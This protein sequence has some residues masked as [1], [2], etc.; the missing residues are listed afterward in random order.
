LLLASAVIAVYL[1]HLMVYSSKRGL[2]SNPRSKFNMS[3]SI[4]IA[5]PWDICGI[6]SSH[7]LTEHHRVEQNQNTPLLSLPAEIRGR[8]WAYAV[9]GA[10]LRPRPINPYRTSGRHH[11]KL[12]PDDCPHGMAL[13]RVCRQIYSE[14]AF[15][16]LKLS[17]LLFDNISHSWITHAKS[18]ISQLKPHQRRQIKKIRFQML[19]IIDANQVDKQEVSDMISPMTKKLPHVEEVRVLYYSLT[20]GTPYTNET[21]TFDQRPIFGSRKIRVTVQMLDTPWVEF[22]KDL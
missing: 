1:T 12:T 3:L 15:L 4:T 2:E 7:K 13:L 6:S 9:G 19:G 22:N 14:A 20:D 16:P 10:T 5:I 11:F 8:I 21:F 17:S 18:A